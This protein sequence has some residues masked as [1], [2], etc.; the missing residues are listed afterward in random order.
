M[1]SD[2]K[3]Y[4]PIAISLGYLHIRWYAIFIMLGALMALV[5]AIREGKKIGIE[6]SFLEDLVLYGL[7]ISI[8]GARIYYV[9]FEWN[10]Y[11]DNLIDIFK[12]NEGGLA[13]HGAIIAA[14]L[15]GYYYCKKHNVNFL[16]VLDL[17][18]VGFLIAQS[19]GRWGN[20]MNQEAYGALVPGK[21]V[22]QQEIFMSDTL[23]LPNFI[24]KQMLINGSQGLGFYHPTFLYESIWNF[25]G[26][27]ILMVLRKTKYLR[28]GDLFPIYLIWYSIGRFY[29]EGLRTD[30]LYIGSTNVKAAQI[31]SILLIIGSIVYFAA[32]YFLSIKKEGA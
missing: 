26:F 21:T 3:P 13:I 15:W 10:Q 22:V 31:M 18:A 27:L 30:S 28:S 9:I 16:H 2:Y 23:N 5:I 11:K 17:G 19:I 25:T 32:R 6:K 14:V 1:L 29:I 8:F 7:P 24:S 20:F 12:I 4:N